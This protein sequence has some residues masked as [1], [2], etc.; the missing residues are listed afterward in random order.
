MF[1]SAYDSHSGEIYRHLATRLS[2]TERAE[3]LL[4][5]TFLRAWKVFSEGGRPDNVRAYLYRIA[6]NLVID[7][8]RRKKEESLD[9]VL[10]QTPWKEPSDPAQDSSYLALAREAKDAIMKL[11]EE[12]GR[13]VAMRYIDDMDISEIAEVL[14]ITANNTSV[15]LHRAV[16][17]LRKILDPKADE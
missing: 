9:E 3:E 16:Q 1:L 12:E 13:L 8:Y 11:P 5:E 14:G 10:E 15:K 6:T 7:E 4:Q 17:K 2:S